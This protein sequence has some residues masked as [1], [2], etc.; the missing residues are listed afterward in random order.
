MKY[1]R[2]NPSNRY[3]HATI[4]I[5]DLSKGNED[6]RLRIQLYSTA[7]VR[8]SLLINGGVSN[9]EYKLTVDLKTGLLYNGASSVGI[10]D[11]ENTLSGGDMLS[12][13]SVH[14]YFG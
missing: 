8:K 6:G 12:L 14:P 1:E 9:G 5:T 3:L 2:T 10:S 11:E 13:V 7:G 4:H